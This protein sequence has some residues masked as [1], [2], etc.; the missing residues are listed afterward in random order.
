MLSN[1]TVLLLFFCFFA[2]GHASYRYVQQRLRGQAD[3]K[4]PQT[5]VSYGSI[6]SNIEESTIQKIHQRF[7]MEKTQSAEDNARVLQQEGSMSLSMSM[8]SSLSIL[9]TEAEEAVSSKAEKKE[10][11]AAKD[12]KAPKSSKAPTATK[13]PKATK[14]ME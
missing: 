1:K 6:L 10:G 12:T 14:V 4:A 3:D 2:V 11:R 8:S 9:E 7:V 13:V 5:M